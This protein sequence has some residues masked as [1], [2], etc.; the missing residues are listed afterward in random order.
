ML[1]KYT[2]NNVLTLNIPGN[3]TS[4]IPHTL[5]PGINEIED[6]VWKELKSQPGVKRLM[7]KSILLEKAPPTKDNKK[8]GKGLAKYSAEEAAFI[9]EETYDKR[10]LSDWLK[11]ESRAVIK[12]AIETQLDVI[13]KSV[14]RKTDEEKD[15]E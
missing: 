6:Q 2:K 12:T 9:V 1:L 8:V 14:E 5:L 7:A 3:G 15:E 4:V 13:E 10:L 11:L